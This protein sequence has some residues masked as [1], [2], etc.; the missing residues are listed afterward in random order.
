MHEVGVSSEHEVRVEN[1]HLVE[2]LECSHLCVV[3]DLNRSVLVLAPVELVLDRADSDKSL[4]SLLL[5]N[6]C[7]SLDEVVFIRGVSEVI[8]SEVQDILCTLESEI[9]ICD[10]LDLALVKLHSSGK[11]PL[12]GIDRLSVRSEIKKS[13]LLI[14]LSSKLCNDT[15]CDGI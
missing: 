5:G 10:S 11:T 2:V 4:D 6:S 12:H 1:G 14:V 9:E 15:S 3:S 13:D 7:G 8:V